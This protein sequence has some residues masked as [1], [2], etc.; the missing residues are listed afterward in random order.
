M[1]TSLSCHANIWDIGICE[2]RHYDSGDIVFLIYHV[3]SRE[4]MFKG[5]CECMGGI[6]SQSHRLPMFGDDWS[7]ASGD[8]KYLIC[9]GA[10]YSVSLPSEI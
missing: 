3:T 4:H 8:R 2:H 7:S 9:H 10:H 5:L 6:P 1:A